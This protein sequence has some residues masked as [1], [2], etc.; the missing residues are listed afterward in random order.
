M[1]SS[2]RNDSVHSIRRSHSTL[3]LAGS[4]TNLFA[5]NLAVLP[6]AMLRL[7]TGF[8]MSSIYVAGRVIMSL[9]SRGKITGDI[10]LLWGGLFHRHGGAFLHPIKRHKV[11]DFYAIVH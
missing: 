7:L 9:A 4:L 6:R 5:L 10:N 8:L 2:A 3:L 1:T 11:I